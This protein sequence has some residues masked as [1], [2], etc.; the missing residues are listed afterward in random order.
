MLY[1]YE[2]KCKG[3]AVTFFF[4]KVAAYV[5]PL[6]I[7]VTYLGWCDGN[8]FLL[9]ILVPILPFVWF[10]GV[11]MHTIGKTWEQVDEMKRQLEEMHREV[12]NSENTK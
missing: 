12:Q 3:L 9:L 2:K 1:G 8:P 6:L 11:V 7:W 5:L 10:D 4:L